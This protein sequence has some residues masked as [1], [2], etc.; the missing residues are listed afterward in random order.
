MKKPPQCACCGNKPAVGR[1]PYRR[2]FL[3]KLLA[4]ALGALALAVPAVVGLISALNPLR[5]K[6]Q[7]GRFFRVTSLDALPEDGTPRRFPIIADRKDAWTLFPNQPIGSVFLRR[8]GPSEVKALAVICPHAGCFI[9]F[10]AKAGGFL[11]PCHMAHFDLDGKRTDEQS[12]SPR[13]M[14]PLEEVEIR[15]K[16]DVYVKF[17][18][19]QTGTPQ[20]IVEA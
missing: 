12:Q 11:C 10:D 20:R 13:D 6:G 14:D 5:V 15:D 7:G 3:S 16:R 9:D 4:L 19:F 8:T 1:G 18:R 17:Q 2:G